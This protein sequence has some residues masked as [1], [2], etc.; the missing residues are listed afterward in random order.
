MANKSIKQAYKK[1][2]ANY[3]ARVRRLQKSGFDVELIK[4]VKNPTKASIK[5]LN[6][7]TAKAIREKSKLY[8]EKGE[9]VTEHRLS[10]AR[11]QY[12]KN[13]SRETFSREVDRAIAENSKRFQQPQKSK[14]QK[15]QVVNVP[16][17]Q[18]VALENWYASINNA[19]APT[20]RDLLI[21]LTENLT[22][23][24]EKEK[25]FVKVLNENPELF[26]EQGYESTTL[27]KARFSVIAKA[28]QDKDI[29]IE[30][31]EL[32]K[33]ID[34]YNFMRSLQEGKYYE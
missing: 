27:I 13:V 24:P 14:S 2:R 12:K 9:L 25:A 11:K 30:T 29:T 17:I 1:A 28:M 33:R 21:N 4:L 22:S 8:N 26:P 16:T 32:D 20:I 34:D 7:Q 10:V 6:A 19:F 3:L 23:T 15:P 18:E 5:R 31:A